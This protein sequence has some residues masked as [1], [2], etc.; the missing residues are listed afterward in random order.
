MLP[1]AFRGNIECS[2]TY[3][4]T[5][6][7]DRISSNLTQFSLIHGKH[8]AFL[9]PD[10]IP[11]GPEGGSAFNDAPDSLNASCYQGTIKIRYNDEIPAVTEEPSQRV[12]T[13]RRGFFGRLFS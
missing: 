2:T 5:I 1:P 3:G 9:S 13:E 12:K 7:S 8:L 11:S 10:P 4:K 6:F